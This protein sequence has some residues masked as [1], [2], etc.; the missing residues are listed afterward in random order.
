MARLLA[1]LGA[2]R[3]QHVVAAGGERVLVRPDPAHDLEARIAAAG[4]DAEQP[5][6]RPQRAR[7][8]PDHLGGLELDRHARAIG[9]RGDDQIVVG[10]RRPWRGITSSSRKRKSSR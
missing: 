1:E 9:L 10:A 7:Q 8:R 2:H 3:A 4:V 5:A 6:A